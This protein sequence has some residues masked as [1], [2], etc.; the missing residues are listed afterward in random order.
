M[1]AHVKAYLLEE[2]ATLSVDVRG[3]IQAMRGSFA[4]CK[5]VAKAVQTKQS[6]AR[7]V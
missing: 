2:L 6:S 5:Y 7:I 4:V 1:G 3:G